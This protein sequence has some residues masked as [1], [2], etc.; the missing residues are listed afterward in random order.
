MHT[1]PATGHG[2][3]F[4]QGEVARWDTAARGQVKGMHAGH[5]ALASL[6]LS[7]LVLRHQESQNPGLLAP[8]WRDLGS[9]E[10]LKTVTQC[11]Q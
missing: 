2:L 1:F 6:S 5:P 11:F 8:E 3:V 9:L 7:E 4:M 10:C